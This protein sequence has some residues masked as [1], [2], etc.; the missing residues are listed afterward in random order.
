MKKHI[1]A[2]HKSPYVVYV[3]LAGLLS[4]IVGLFWLPSLHKAVLTHPDGMSEQAI[5]DKK[6][7]V[8]ITEGII[9]KWQS[10][11]DEKYIREFTPHEVVE[12]YDGEEVSRDPYMLFEGTDVPRFLVEH[13]EPYMVYLMI[14]TANNNPLMFSINKFD[15]QHL[16]T[17]YLS[18]GTMLRYTRI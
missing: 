14:G 2:I 3:Y 13:A 7:I 15:H 8:I 16:E 17:F 18:R 4:V 12:W 11:D 10:R 5:R 9:G 6:E 1:R